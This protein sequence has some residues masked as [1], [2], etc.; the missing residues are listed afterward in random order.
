MRTENNKDKL[1]SHQTPKRLVIGISGASGVIMGIRILE[2]LYPIKEI[3]THL[4]MSPAAKVT[5][6]QETDWKI[7]DVSRAG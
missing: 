2:V 1:T 6:S 7:S 4:V 3:E 5:I